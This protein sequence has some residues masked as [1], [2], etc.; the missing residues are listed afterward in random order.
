MVK[1]SDIKATVNN[2]KIVLSGNDYT[3]PE[4]RTFHLQGEV[5]GFDEGRY[6][7][8]TPIIAQ[9]N[10]KIGTVLVTYSGS[11]YLLEKPESIDTEDFKQMRKRLPCV[12]VPK[13]RS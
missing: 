7:T 8:T 5:E 4:C 9:K 6:M 13:A 12:R 2:W 10:C 1:L 3:A 11:L